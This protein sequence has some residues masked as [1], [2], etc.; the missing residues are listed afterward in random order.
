M[1]FIDQVQD[2]TSLTVSDNDEL[3]QFL[4][5]GVIDV[6]S[7]W[8][9][10][11][12]QDLELFARESAEQTS[13]ASLHLN[14]AKIISVI[15]ENGTNNQWRNCRKISPAQQY[16]VTDK[17]SL[18]YAS[19]INPAYMVGNNG[20]LSV[21]PTPQSTTD[22]FKVYYVN[23]DPEDK[24]GTNLIHSHSD[25]GY[26]PDDKVYLVVIY[27]GM[28]LLQAAMGAKTISDLSITAVPPDTPSAPNFS[29]A[30]VSTTTAGSLGTA[31]TY[32]SPTTT[33]SGTAW[34]TAY[35]DQHSA[36][37]TAWT[38]MNSE[39]DDCLALAD[40]M[41]EQI[42]SAEA[43]Y[44]KFRADAGDPALFGDESQYLTGL[45]MTHVKDALELAR[46]AI[47]TGFTTD[48]DAGSGNATP[49][50]VGYWLA[51]EDTEMVAATLQT[52]QTEIQRAQAHIAEWNATVQSLNVEAQGFLATSAGFGAQIQ[53]RIAT[54]NAYAQEAASRLS[55]IGIR[56][57]EYQ[58][59]VQDATAT[60]NRENAIYQSTVQEAL[61]ELQ[62]A[63][64]K[65]QKDA[66]LSQQKEIAEYSNRLQRFQNE[67]GAYSADVNNQIQEYTANLQAD[68][69]E[70]QW[71]QSQYTT[72]AQEYA[73]AFAIAAPKQQQVA[74]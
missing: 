34:A 15:R 13:N 39:I 62:I 12:P 35:P 6:T 60:F 64:A 61:Q 48:E 33:I 43:A 70:Y 32:T 69:T 18:N 24:G 21:F 65:A 46:D 42:E 28:K 4:K 36:I 19:K 45:G 58:A 63:S 8:L 52:A 68:T 47:D 5:D 31:P 25:I 7:K 72:L 74:R 38:A 14:G 26:F 29:G 22:A 37:G 49:Y 44:D 73:S 9:A 66:D 57:N 54:A 17:E 30:T 40:D 53:S 50:S 2:L 56:V 55:Q 23:N 51:D 3:S 59:R 67:I 20:Q 1:A 41:D 71:L 16:D 10:I 11:K 27:A